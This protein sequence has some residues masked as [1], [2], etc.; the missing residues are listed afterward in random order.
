MITITSFLPSRTAPAGMLLISWFIMLLCKIIRFLIIIY[1][2]I[3]LAG[4]SASFIELVAIMIVFLFIILF[5]I[6]VL[7]WIII[8]SCWIWVTDWVLLKG[9]VMVLSTLGVRMSTAV[10]TISVA[11]LGVITTLL[12]VIPWILLIWIWVGTFR[13]TPMIGVLAAV[14]ELLPASGLASIYFLIS[15]IIVFTSLIVIN[16]RV[17]TTLLQ[18][19]IVLM[20]LL[21]LLMIYNMSSILDIIRWHTAGI[22]G[23][24]FIWSHL[25]CGIWRKLTIK[26]IKISMFFGKIRN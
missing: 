22:L 15:S 1:L 8:L 14:L 19:I 16:C 25:I 24:A 4:I 10:A 2:L 13:T 3:I 20:F 21:L 18:L 11:T 6:I 23:L 9:W 12:L 7:D 17:G 5:Y 26:M